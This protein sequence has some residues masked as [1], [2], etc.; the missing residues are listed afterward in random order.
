MDRCNSSKGV[1]DVGVAFR[2]GDDGGGEER[3]DDEG[4]GDDGGVVA[5]GEAEGVFF[6]S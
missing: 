3:P 6:C 4:S 2:Y 1:P 5:A